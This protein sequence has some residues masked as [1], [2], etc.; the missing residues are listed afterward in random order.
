MLH[1]YGRTLAVHLELTWLYP[2]SEYCSKQTRAVFCK[3][4][5]SVWASMAALTSC[6]RIANSHVLLI[7]YFQPPLGPYLER[8]GLE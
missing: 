6:T 1:R 7:T 3:F 2:L 5:L 8:Y 4:H